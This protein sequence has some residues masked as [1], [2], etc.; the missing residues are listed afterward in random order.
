MLDD[1]AKAAETFAFRYGWKSNRNLDGIAS[2]GH[3][4]H[5]I[6]LGGRTNKVDKTENLRRHRRYAPIAAWWGWIRANLFAADTRLLR[7]YINSHTFGVEGYPHR[8]SNITGELTCITY[9][10]REWR[11]EWAGETVLFSIDDEIERAVMPKFGRV[12]IFPSDKWHAARAVSRICPVAR[13][14]LV[15]KVGPGPG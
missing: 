9:L 4:N 11:R 7:L 5:D 8:D 15:L 13:A 6:A 3:W 12:F 14:T 1:V 2:A 10:N